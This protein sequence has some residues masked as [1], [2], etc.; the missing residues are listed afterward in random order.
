MHAGAGRTWCEAELPT[1]EHPAKGTPCVAG[2]YHF[3]HSKRS[4]LDGIQVRQEILDRDG[5]ADAL[6]VLDL[7]DDVPRFEAVAMG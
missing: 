7:G 5:P 4:V 6:A 3:R 1:D 2:H